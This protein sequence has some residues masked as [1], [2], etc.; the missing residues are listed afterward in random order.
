M[1]SHS[2]LT[3]VAGLLTLSLNIATAQK[4][5]YV[6]YFGPDGLGLDFN[7]CSPSVVSDGYPDNYA[8]EGTTSICDG[9]TGGLLF[10]TSGYRVY[11]SLRQPMLNGDPVGLSNS[12]AQMVIAPWPGNPSKYFIFIPEVQAGVSWQPNHPAA[13]SLYYA[14]VDMSLDGGLGGVESKFNVLLTSQHCEFLTVIPHANGSDYWLVGHSFG[15]EQ[16]FNYAITS[17]GVAT[18]PQ[19][20]NIGPV[21][22]TPQP[23][24][25][26]SSNIDAVGGMRAS[27]DGTR[28]AFTT[29]YNGITCVLEFDPSTGAFSSPIVL[30][31]PGGGYGLSFSPNGSKLYIGV[32]NPQIGNSFEDGAL[33]QFDLDGG[34]QTAIQNSLTVLHQIAGD[35]GFATLK[36]GPDR[37][38]YVARISS[39][40]TSQGDSFLGVVNEP[41]LAG[42][43][44]DYVHDGVWLNGSFAGWGLNNSLEYGHDCREVGMPV[45]TEC[46]VLTMR[47]MGNRRTIAWPCADSFERLFVYGANGKIIATSDVRP[48]KSEVAF[49]LP[50]DASGI[51][52]AHLFG[53]ASSATYKFWVE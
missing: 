16:F 32:K 28:L 22:A 17:S 48:G 42:T 13:F 1:T 43:L 4:Q 5:D 11:N 35:G 40:G 9:A 46:N 44:S 52:L 30:S 41:D 34:T 53:S 12:L 15:N 14:V 3:I 31:I 6:W 37:R 27:P 26:N 50:S 45:L 47:S 2:R 39:N 20:Q 23:G 29:C 38:L 36:L 24:P 51:Y 8:W 7:G 33:V 25:P 10:Y 19:F 49:H 18:I 21:V